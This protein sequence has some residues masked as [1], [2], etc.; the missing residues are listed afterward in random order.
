MFTEALKNDIHAIFEL[1]NELIERVI[2]LDDKHYSHLEAQ[3]LGLLVD[4]RQSLYAALINMG[5]IVK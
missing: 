2:G 4:S 3:I 5:K 1:N